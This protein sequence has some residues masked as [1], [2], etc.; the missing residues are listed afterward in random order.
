MVRAR[1]DGCGMRVRVRVKAHVSSLR[2]GDDGDVVERGDGRALERRARQ[3]RVQ[4]REPLELA[5]RR[6]PP[7]GDEELVRAHL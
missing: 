1:G 2:E 7:E 6:E 5:R 4:S 3:Q